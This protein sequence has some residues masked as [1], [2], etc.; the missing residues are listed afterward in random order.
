MP[1]A[2]GTPDSRVPSDPFKDDPKVPAPL[3]A[4]PPGEPPALP[5]AADPE[6][7]AVPI[8]NAAGKFHELNSHGAKPVQKKVQPAAHT[9]ALNKFFHEVKAGVERPEAPAAATK[10]PASNTGLKWHNR[11][12][13]PA[14]TPAAAA[15]AAT[16]PARA[17]VSQP[18]TRSVL[19]SSLIKFENAE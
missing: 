9:Q 5:P 6:A 3:G 12:T 15:P 4:E 8:E 11:S 14:P 13:S 7:P 16:T 18:A 17:E 10:I 2:T 19:P 1:P